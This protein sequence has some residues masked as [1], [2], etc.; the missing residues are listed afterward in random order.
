MKLQN[1]SKTI[2]ILFCTLISIFTILFVNMIIKIIVFT[3]TE[4]KMIVGKEHTLTIHAPV[5]ASVESNMIHSIKVNGQKAQFKEEFKKIEN[6][7][8]LRTN[9]LGKI[10][11]KLKLFGILPIK[12]MTIDVMPDVQVIPCGKTVGVKLYTKGILILGTGSIKGSDSRKHEPSAKKV[13]VGDIILSINGKKITSLYQLKTILNQNKNKEVT[14]EILTDDKKRKVK[15]KPIQDIEDGNY[16]LGLW[17]REGTQGIGTV[18]F[19]DPKNKKFGALGHAITDI[20]TEKIMLLEKGEILSS[21][22]HAVKKGRR[23]QPGEL[24]GYFNDNSKVLG[25]IKSNTQNG[26]FGHI[27]S[28]NEKYFEGK[29]YPIALK[30]EIREGKA[31]ILS[32]INGTKVENFDIIIQKIYRFNQS[33]MK[34]MIIKVVDKKLI[35]KTGG[36][37]QGMSGSP[38][39]QNGKIVG[40]VTHVFVNDPTKGFG[41]FIENMIKSERIALK[42]TDKL[43]KNGKFE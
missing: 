10:D 40:A 5:T 11:I 32:N 4:Q 34:Q 41:I 29:A 38:I 31:Q 3:P 26:I 12:T 21:Q 15:I 39:L 2:S 20:D 1:K 43:V 24:I 22:I 9:E 25:D 23:G 33:D 16:K 17:A 6:A 8:V 7:F 37:V 27:Y 30:N 19:Y 13:A 36:I 14:I 18:T 35:N 42:D 28:H